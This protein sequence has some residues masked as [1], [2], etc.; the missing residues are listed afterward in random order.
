MLEGWR[1]FLM[2]LIVFLVAVLALTW[3]GIHSRMM[4]HTGLLECEK[5]HFDSKLGY[6]ACVQARES[7]CIR[8]ILEHYE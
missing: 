7:V 2:G 6:Y 3:L 5:L 1:L 8:Q 4:G